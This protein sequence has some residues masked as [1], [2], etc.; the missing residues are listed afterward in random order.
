MK[1]A[2]SKREQNK[3]RRRSTIVEIATRAFLEHGYAATSM[4]AIADELGGSKATLWSHFS[5]KEELFT[6]VVDDLVERFGA[7]LQSTLNAEGFSIDALR[8]YC[9]GFLEKLVTEESVLLFRLIMAD[10]GR[11]PE[12]NAVFHVRGPSRIQRLLTAFFATRFTEDN[13]S[14]LAML[15]NATLVGYR[16]HMLTRPVLPTLL[17]R[18]QFVDEFIAHL[19]LPE[20]REDPAISAH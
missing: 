10:G 17:E 18:E 3:L 11:F 16:T 5:S 15:T 6:A 13:A 7:A 12:I 9:L 19:R 4:S 2:L 8:R 20:P 1:M 14:T